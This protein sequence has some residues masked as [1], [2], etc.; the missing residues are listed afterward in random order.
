MKLT[1]FGAARAVTGSCH[2]LECG[3]QK[4]LL[5]CGL[6][7]GKDE[8]DGGALHFPAAQID[9]LIVSH[10]HIDHTGRIPLLVKN[11][12]RGKIH[13]TRL[14]AELMDIMLR[15]SAHIQESNVEYLNRKR[16]RAG[17][18]PIDALY[19][20]A[21]VED[22]MKLVVP[23][24]YGEMIELEGGVT[25]R[26]SDAGHLLGSAF[27]ELWA[28]E[29]GV[30]RKLVFSGDIGN[31]D[32]PIIRDP[33]LIHEADYV[34]MESTYGDREH[35][36]SE[37]EYSEDLARILD[38]TFSKG[39]SVIIPAFAVGRTQELLYFFR[40]IK[41]RGLVKSLPDFPV[42]LDSPLAHA[43]TQVFMSD[44]HGYLDEDALEL[45]ESGRRVLTFPGLVLCESLEESKKL[46]ADRKPKVIIS[47]S[48]M[49]DAG[50]IRH[51][52]KHNLWRKECTVLFVGY[53]AEG[54]FGRRLLDMAAAKKRSAV[55]MFGDEVA[56]A[57]RIIN[58]PG[59]SGHAGLSGLL[60]FVRAF[61]PKP[62]HIFVVH[63]DAAVAPAFAARL[64]E[65]GYA[66]HA[67]E[68]TE[69]YD[70]TSGEVERNG[71]TPAR[72]KRAQTESDA[73]TRLYNLGLRLMAV[74]EQNKGLA[75]AHLRKFADQLQ[76]LIS[77]WE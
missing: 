1:F 68:Y 75:N 29:S 32:Q 77:K 6:Q 63:G 40:E 22:A 2:L 8:I 11:G 12:F 20:L 42:Y 16:A 21:D 71:V 66:A 55:K 13:A 39:G 24:E 10:A 46:N 18:Q 23:H 50:R 28:E 53:Q 36:P 43:A 17:N 35:D 48:G 38:Q 58:F 73:Y 69:V 70:L 64:R 7:Q 57:A 72:K 37:H 14:T 19:T 61:D 45:V 25:L 56:V 41:E 49:C 62:R 4:L 31:T 3:G 9:A 67:P 44:L 33:Q 30:K 47:A 27:V 34:I 5:D 65:M 52:L 54:T 74:I 26:F 15:D 60:D 76:T 59:L 51:H